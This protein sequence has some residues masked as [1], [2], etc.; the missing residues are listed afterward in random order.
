ML[1]TP[2]QTKKV[3]VKGPT[4]AVVL[5]KQVRL[6]FRECFNISTSWWQWHS[7]ALEVGWAQGFG[8]WKNAGN[9]QK[10]D[11]HTQSAADKC[12]LQAVQHTV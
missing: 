2:L 3:K 9:P 4:F 12:I 7:E 8:V 1:T 10:P 5:L 11:T 6:A